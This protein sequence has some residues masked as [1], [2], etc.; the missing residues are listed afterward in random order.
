MNIQLR[1]SRIMSLILT[2]TALL[3]SL[4]FMGYAAPNVVLAA[5]TTLTITV[6]DSSMPTAKPI[7]GAQLSL[8]S[9]DSTN[10]VI[11]AVSSTD[12]NGKCTFTLTDADKA[13]FVDGSN[14]L[15]AK[16]TITGIPDGTTTY[17]LYNDNYTVSGMNGTNPTDTITIPAARFSGEITPALGLKYSA[18]SQTVATI[19]GITTGYSVYYAVKNSTGYESFTAISP[20]TGTGT[21]TV[22]AAPAVGTTT[23][24]IKI[25]NVATGLYEIKDIPVTVQANDSTLQF[26]AGYP[27]NV[28][29]TDNGVIV[30]ATGTGL[31]DITYS[32]TNTAVAT[33]DSSTGQLTYVKPGTTTITATDSSGNYT[34]SFDLTV[35]KVD[36]SKYKLVFPNASNGQ[37]STTYNKTNTFP[38]SAKIVDSNGNDAPAN[39]ANKFTIQYSIDANSSNTA[40]ASVSTSG[41]VTY[42]SDGAATIMATASATTEGSTYL[43]GTPVSASYTATINGLETQE[44]ATPSGFVYKKVDTKTQYYCYAAPKKSGD[45]N[46]FLEAPA[47]FSIAT[48]AADI[49]QDTSWG[50]TISFNQQTNGVVSNTKLQYRLKDSKGNITAVITPAQTQIIAVDAVNPEV[51]FNIEKTGN[52]LYIVSFGLFGHEDIKVT[53]TGKDA[54]PSSNINDIQLFGPTDSDKI[55]GSGVTWTTPADGSNGSV[56][57]NTFTINVKKDTDFNG[58]I[59]AKVTDNA[60]NTS[61]NVLATSSNTTAVNPSEDKSNND[62]KG[63][64]ILSQ[65]GPMVDDITATQ[66][67]GVNKNNSYSTL[68]NDSK[69]YITGNVDLSSNISSSVAGLKSVN[70]TINGVECKPTISVP[71]STTE[72]DKVSHKVTYNLDVTN[73]T[74]KSKPVAQTDGSYDVLITA[75]DNAGNTNTKTLTLY[76]DITAATIKNISYSPTTIPSGSGSDT[77]I[78]NEKNEYGFY[79]N[80]STTATITAEDVVSSNEVASGVASISYKLVDDKGSVISSISAENVAVNAD[81]SIQVTLAPNVKGYLKAYA[82]D[83]LGQSGSTYRSKASDS[84]LHMP[85]GSDWNTVLDQKGYCQGKGVIVENMDSQHFDTSEIDITDNNTTSYTTDKLSAEPFSSSVQTKNTLKKGTVYKG[86]E[87]NLNVYPGTSDLTFNLS[88]EDTYSGIKQIDMKVFEADVKSTTLS[89]IADYTDTATVGIDGTVEKYWTG[90]TKDNN[91]LTAA[92]RTLTLDPKKFTKQTVYIQVILTDNAGNTTYNYYAFAL[93][94]T[95]P[96]V[97]KITIDTKETTLWEKLGDWVYSFFHLGTKD[98]KDDPQVVTVEVKDKAPTSGLKTVYLIG[99][100]TEPFAQKADTVDA[101]KEVKDGNNDITYTSTFNIDPNF[102]GTLKAYVI[103]NAANQSDDKYVSAGDVEENIAKHKETSTI[104]L[105]PVADN[106]GYVTS[107]TANPFSG[108]EADNSLFNA[109][110]ELKVYNGQDKLNFD[111]GVTD[112]Y[113]GIKQIETKVFEAD[114]NS[115][116]LTEVKDY[117]DTSTVDVDGKLTGPWSGGNKD[118]N[119]L[120]AATRTLTLEP[121]KFTKQVAYIQ[122]ILTD[123]AGNV[124]YNYYAF[125]L[126]KTKPSIQS[127]YITHENSSTVAKIINNLSFG[128]FCKEKIIV[129]VTAKDNQPSA[130]ITEAADIQLFSLSNA[131]GKKING[132]WRGKFSEEKPGAGNGYTTTARSEFEIDPQYEGYLYAIVKDNATLTNDDSNGTKATGSNTMVAT[133]DGDQ[134][135]N[136]AGYILLETT[137]PELYGFDNAE[138]QILQTTGV[139]TGHGATDIDNKH[140]LSGDADLIFYAQDASTSE[141][142]GSGL[143]NVTITADGKDI[144]DIASE[145]GVSIDQIVTITAVDASGG[146]STYPQ[147]FENASSKDNQK[148]KYTIHTNYLATQQDGSINIA[149]MAK[150]N[151]L[152]S[153][154]PINV[155]V[156]KDLTAATID[157]FTFSKPNSEWGLGDNHAVDAVITDY[158]YYFKEDVDVT[159]T[160]QDIVGSNEAATGVA[161]ITYKAV[162]I[163]KGVVVSGTQNGGSATFRVNKDFK[164][165]I[166]AYATDKL[167]QS[168]VS[169]VNRNNTNGLPNLPAGYDSNKIGSD[170]FVHPDGSVMESP[171]KHTTTSS[172]SISAPAPEGTEDHSSSYSDGNPTDQSMDYK[173]DQMV[174][175]YNHD[176]SF[177]LNVRDSYSGIAKV[178]CRQIDG[179]GDRIIDE[180]SFDNTGKESSQGQWSVDT[181]DLN[182]VTSISSNI[183]VTSN[184][185]DVVLR[186][187]LTDRSGNTSYDYYMFGID[188]TAPVIDVSY[189][190]NNPD[191]QSGD[192]AYYKDNRTATI[193]VTERNFD[194]NRVNFY[195]TKNGASMPV[196][197]GWSYNQAGGN[198]DE[199]THVA[200]IVYSEDADYTFNMDCTDRATNASQGVNYHGTTPTNFTVD[201]TAPVVTVTYDNNTVFNGKYFNANRVATITVQE[202]NFDVNRMTEAI[203]AALDGQGIAVPG[204]SWS[205]DGDTHYGTVAFNTDGD[206]TLNVTQARDMA[207]NDFAG[208]SYNASAAQD[209]TIDT[210]IEKPKIRGVENQK[211]YK[212]DFAVGFD[213]L[214]INFDT[215]S[216]KLTRTRWDKKDE[217]VTGDFIT[218]VSRSAK[219]DVGDGN[220]V[221]K[222]E[223][224]DGIYTLKLGITDKA[225]NHAEESIT[226]SVNRYGSVYVLSDYLSD[227]VHQG[228][229]KKIEKNLDIIEYNPDRL[230]GDSVDIQATRDSA[231]I[232]NLNAH[233]TPTPSGS[234]GVGSSGWYE[235]THTLDASK[236]T[237]DGIYSIVVASQDEAGNKPQNTNYEDKMISFHVDSVKPE[238]QDVEGLENDT[239]NAVEADVKYKAFDAIGLANA[240]VVVDNK[241]VADVKNFEQLTTYN[242]E[243]KLSEGVRQ[244][245]RIILTDKAGNKLDTSDPSF[246]ASYTFNK[247]VTVSTNFFV[248]WFAN[249]YRALGTG[250]VAAALVAFIIFLLIKRRKKDDDDGSEATK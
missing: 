155:T 61:G 160:A 73:T 1:K 103:D 241:T 169:W 151:A 153:A 167:G 231:P 42:T 70:M 89:S 126:D 205:G 69:K 168:T 203:T 90:G 116:A 87:K 219:G 4:I 3:L 102:K 96:E 250:I 145:K 174:P 232:T 192:H 218:H 134:A 123:N 108:V 79:V 128:L 41:Q 47:G 142:T 223:E 148:Y 189:D 71:I 34:A 185:N 197:V 119:L 195:V 80:Q 17:A 48:S 12:E 228:Y 9:K 249:A 244:K 204:V 224:L 60:G 82:T 20:G 84:P 117:A 68:A 152:N 37:Y 187:E 23:Y 234:V 32:S 45:N 132:S 77:P 215:D 240:K 28:L 72:I 199:S 109:S 191:S 235:Y 101:K 141:T 35:T 202:H 40:N 198:G 178:V 22:Q 214:D 24:G 93:D 98:G 239:I 136:S 220:T 173:T 238:L 138:G 230:V 127:F 46:I 110:Q 196:N 78:N 146:K 62:W 91:L 176:I 27:T 133:A 33:V 31:T 147:D 88:V 114:V 11:N 2:T 51:S 86:T 246:T 39:I 227:V 7:V 150:D 207:G 216:I 226:F 54:N 190:N 166:Y 201:K 21:G 156:Y 115:T 237:K 171:E 111:L 94:K 184:Y 122:V 57:T 105:T 181:R 183:G 137:P 242:G 63:Q 247:V 172:I 121:S 10:K 52:W 65:K 248:R 182:L 55:T 180:V 131:D 58:Q 8:Q 236:F 162:D 25:L 222:K 139:N 177:N 213:I 225:T 194:E 75:T 221:D 106:K 208:A 85:V 186:V 30:K 97:T 206:Y 124:T 74:D 210:K 53:V 15:D 200:Q 95:K 170:G 29:W 143:N 83:K 243:F 211:A 36:V 140:Y 99:E 14:Q 100:G 129:T 212:D 135:I 6:N 26:N 67:T 76:A 113:S 16:L 43:S 175:L 154:N 81:N 209:F 157:Q 163:D 149:V 13:N 107:S 229:V 19:T 120:T 49:T 92:T 18:T 44:T 66:T 38:N 118:K 144:K 158:G 159:V 165:Q 193:T 112:T 188:K 5:D 179:T 56:A 233:T 164:G 59:W 161:S 245:V 130:G 104:T 50:S 64:I 125:S 217:D